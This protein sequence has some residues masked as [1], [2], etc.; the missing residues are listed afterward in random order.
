M[1]NI[2]TFNFIFLLLLAI[3][4]FQA[5]N[6]PYKNTIKTKEDLERFNQ[7]EKKD[8]EDRK[9]TLLYLKWLQVGSMILFSSGFLL[10]LLNMIFDIESN[11]EPTKY[12]GLVSII[13]IVSF[14][15]ILFFSYINS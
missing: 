10:I 11:L 12:L 9:D 1:H 2:F 5:S 14:G 13:L 7:L 15:I 6:R 8:L 4:F 3:Y